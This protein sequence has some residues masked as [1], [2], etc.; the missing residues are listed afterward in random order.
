MASAL[1]VF[2]L[3]SGRY[4]YL[5]APMGLSSS[6]DEWCQHFD[7]V[8]EGLPWKKKIVDDILIWAP[9]L[10]TLESR[11][12][13]FLNRCL[14]INVT[15]CKSK[16]EIGNKLHFSGFLFNQDGVHPDPKGTKALENFPDPKPSQ[17][18]DRSSVWLTSLSCLYQILHTQPPV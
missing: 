9:D 3:S 15:I 16:F 4:R 11:L 12:D 18:C 13:T 1:I 6:S 8:V 7:R 17:T 5:R 2:L 14:N 10:Y